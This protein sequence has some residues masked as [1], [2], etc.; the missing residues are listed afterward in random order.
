MIRNPSAYL[1]WA[2]RT[3]SV[4][5]RNSLFGLA[6]SYIALIPAIYQ[7]GVRIGRVIFK[8]KQRKS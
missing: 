4:A 2:A 6:M 5:G 3:A 1:K 7:G 8:L